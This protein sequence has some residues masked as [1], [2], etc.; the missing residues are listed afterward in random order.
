MNNKSGIYQIRNKS[1]G[2]V[3]VG[4]TVDFN[5]RWVSGHRRLLRRNKHCNRHLQSVW[6]KYGEENFV[7]E[8]L[9]EVKD[10][11]LLIE[12][13]QHFFDTMKPEYNICK[14]AGNTLGVPSPTKGKTGIFSKEVLKK[15][16][17]AAKERGATAEKNPNVKL[18]W[19]IVNEMREFWSYGY[20]CSQISCMYRVPLATVKCILRNENW[21]DDSYNKNER[22]FPVQKTKDFIKKYWKVTEVPATK[23]M[24]LRTEETKGKIKQALKGRFCG[25]KNPNWK[26]GKNHG[27]K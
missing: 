6:N 8:M 27:K 21:K 18:N 23:K 1:D 9:E 2:K 5:K 24:E 25:D 16:S 13:E 17:I 10:K 11:T 22:V 19:K 3:Y 4:S 20:T 14:T 26:G 15:M 12:R 7:F